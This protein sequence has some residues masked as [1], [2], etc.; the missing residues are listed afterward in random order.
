[1]KPTVARLL[2]A[3]ALTTMSAAAFADGIDPT[4]LTEGQVVGQIIQLATLSGTIGT[5]A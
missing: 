4:V 1:M 5:S 3:T 2:G